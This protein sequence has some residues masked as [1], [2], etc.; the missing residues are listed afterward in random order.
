MKTDEVEY[1]YEEQ[2]KKLLVQFLAIFTGIQVKS[3]RTNELES[4]FIDVQVK[5]GSSDRVVAAIKSDNTQNKPMRL[6]MIAGTLVNIDMSPEL[7]H[8]TRTERT[9]SKFPSGGK[10]PEDLKT[11]RQLMPIPYNARFELNIFASSQEQHYEMLE[12]ILLLFDPTLELYTSDELFDWTRLRMLELTDINFD[13]QLAG[14]DRRIIQTSLSFKSPIYL[15]LPAQVRSN[16][17]A[18]IR[19]RVGAVNNLYPVEDALSQLDQDGIEY[20][21]IAKIGDLSLD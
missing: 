17:I 13:E 2:L 11:V 10:F 14:V 18:E 19:L 8:G 6:P 4:R 12:Q 1:Y 20:Q 7:R 16:Y 5:N 9:F 21:T 3:G 15:T